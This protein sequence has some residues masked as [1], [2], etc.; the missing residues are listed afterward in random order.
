VGEPA[1]HSGSELLVFPHTLPKMLPGSFCGSRHAGAAAPPAAA[2]AACAAAAPRGLRLAGRRGAGPCCRPSSAPSHHHHHHHQQQQPHR[3]G[4][5]VAARAR[6]GSRTPVADATMMSL[7]DELERLKTADGRWFFTEG[8]QRQWVSMSV[9]SVALVVAAGLVSVAASARQHEDALACARVIADHAE[10]HLTSPKQSHDHQPQVDAMELD[11]LTPDLPQLLVEMGIRYDPDK[12]AATL[13]TKWPQVRGQAAAAAAAAAATAAAAKGGAAAEA[14]RSSSSIVVHITCT[15]PQPTQPN[16]QVYG[17]A[18]RIAA[19]LGGFIA[20]VGRDYALGSID[21]NAPARAVELRSLLS[22]LGPSFVKIGQALS[23]RP[24]LLPQVYLETL[25][26]L[27]VGLA[28]GGR[29]LGAGGLAVGGGGRGVF[30][31]RRWLARRKASLITLTRPLPTHRDPPRTGCPPS[32]PRSRSPSSRRSRGAPS[33]RYTPRYRSS[34]WPPR[35]WG[36]CVFDH[37]VTSATCRHMQSS[38]CC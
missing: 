7:D 35:R 19:S 13:S 4:S 9:A 15:H 32:P 11:T 22:G 20:K 14:A 5:S 36:R 26:D 34:P 37:R 17:R 6:S 30:E 18:V 38:A 10:R 31:G 23:A 29:R 2:H 24:D 8:G 12:L 21:R 16:Q 25:A 1:G 33:S 27:Q 28:V 3:R